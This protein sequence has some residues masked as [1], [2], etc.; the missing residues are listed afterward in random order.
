LSTSLRALAVALSLVSN[1]LT[2]TRALAK[3]TVTRRQGKSSQKQKV[4][5]KN[6]KKK[7]RE[8]NYVPM[9]SSTALRISRHCVPRDRNFCIKG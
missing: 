6:Q 3:E 2:R 9:D 7:Q 1:E 8:L 4:A 5:R